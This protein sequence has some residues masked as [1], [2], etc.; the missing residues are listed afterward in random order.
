MEYEMDIQHLNK[1]LNQ[2]KD[3][4]RKKNDD[5]AKHM[6]S[7]NFFSRKISNLYAIKKGYCDQI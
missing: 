7:L 5:F 6:I 4:E 2:K 3:D 1:E